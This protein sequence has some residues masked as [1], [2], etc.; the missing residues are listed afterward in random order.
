MTQE[1]VRRLLDELGGRATV[2][3][4][5]TLAKEKFPDRSLHTYVGQLLGRLEKKGF[6]AEVGTQVWELTEKGK[7]TSISGVEVSKVDAEIDKSTLNEN[8]LEVTNIV[9]TLETDREFDLNVLADVLPDAEYHPE[10]SP[11]MVYRPIESATLLVPT[12]GLISVV[13]AKN[14]DQTK[15]A[16]RAFFDEMDTLGVEIKISPDE[17]L[18]QNIVI[19]GDLGVELDLDV[20]S[21]GIGLE[22]CEYEPEQFPGIIFRNEL[23]ATVLIF[24]TGKFVITGSKSYAHAYQVASDLYEELQSLGIAVSSN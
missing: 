9:G 18:V 22:R 4:I 5:S 11:F 10:S 17:I 15:Q 2:E 14:P 8:G 24:R 7:S 12:N 19:N 20:L 16:V 13:G 1:D 23:G 3:E 6:V 21:I